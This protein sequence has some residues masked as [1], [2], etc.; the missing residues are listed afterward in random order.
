[1][2]I[3]QLYQYDRENGRITVSPIKPE[4]EYTEMYR[5]IAEEGKTLVKGDISSPCV[6]T[7]DK[8]GWEE[9]EELEEDN[10]KEMVE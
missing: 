5:L 1:M 8:D 3:K 4:C 6:D 7:Y 2:K 9:I 10:N